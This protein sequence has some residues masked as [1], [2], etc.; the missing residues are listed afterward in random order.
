[1]YDILFKQLTQSVSGIFRLHDRQTYVVGK[2]NAI[3]AILDDKGIRSYF[4][5]KTGSVAQEN[6]LIGFYKSGV[7]KRRL[8]S[9]AELA[10]A[11]LERKDEFIYRVRLR[12]GG[13][14]VD[15][16]SYD[17]RVT[18]VAHESDHTTR[19]RNSLQGV[20][21]SICLGLCSKSSIRFGKLATESTEK[22]HK[23]LESVTHPGSQYK[24]WKYP[25]T[26]MTGGLLSYSQALDQLCLDALA[27]LDWLRARLVADRSYASGLNL[28]VPAD[29]E[30]INSKNASADYIEEEFETAEKYINATVKHVNSARDGYKL[31]TA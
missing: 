10:T 5:D 2:D 24:P 4:L 13:V 17:E 19:L 11:N 12:V 22:C 9:F 30:S 20:S 31:L 1:M 23:L 7:Q 8:F 18:Y 29:R 28:I 27:E 6:A 14:E 26:T 15:L 16:D 25:M 3:L 21:E